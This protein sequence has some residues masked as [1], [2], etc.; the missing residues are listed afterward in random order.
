MR[1]LTVSLTTFTL[2]YMYIFHKPT[3]LN[4]T[5]HLLHPDKVEKFF[6]PNDPDIFLDTN[7]ETKLAT[8]FTHISSSQ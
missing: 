4:S 5:D 7:L 8:H 6:P 3:F 2:T 1:K